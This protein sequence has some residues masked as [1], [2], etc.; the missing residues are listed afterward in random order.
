M[1]SPLQGKKNFSCVNLYCLSGGR[2]YILPQRVRDIQLLPVCV[3]LRTHI[4]FFFFFL[5]FPQQLLKPTLRCKLL[6][7]PR[8]VPRDRTEKPSPACV[9]RSDNSSQVFSP[10]ALF[11]D[12]FHPSQVCCPMCTWKATEIAWAKWGFVVNLGGHFAALLHRKQP[13][14]PGCTWRRQRFAREKMPVKL[15]QIIEEEVFLHYIHQ[16]Q[17]PVCL[18]IVPSAA[19]ECRLWSSDSFRCT[20]PPWFLYYRSLLS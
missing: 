20:S 15:R 3:C 17:T 4:F 12:A 1:W 11:L 9:A 10:S 7:R 14:E 5:F 2:L 13:L 6:P 8:L 19:P 18:F 16:S